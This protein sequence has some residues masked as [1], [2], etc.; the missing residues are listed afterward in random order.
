M[1]QSIIK[2]PYTLLRPL[3]NCMSP[4]T[5]ISSTIQDHLQ[6]IFGPYPEHLS[7]WL[8]H[9]SH[10]SGTFSTLAVY[11]PKIMRLEPYPVEILLASHETSSGK[12][13]WLH[14]RPLATCRDGPTRSRTG[15]WIRRW[16]FWRT[17]TILQG[18]WLSRGPWR[19][20]RRPAGIW[21]HTAE[22][23]IEISSS[24]SIRRDWF[25]G[26][27]MLSLQPW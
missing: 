24:I 26:L 4:Y 25:K 7:A 9:V 6:G 20:D 11:T 8:R 18:L 22:C 16:C 3:N 17:R 13:S 1:S 10:W 5:L 15:N 21:K 2:R 27:S 14:I 12:A 23:L 19:R